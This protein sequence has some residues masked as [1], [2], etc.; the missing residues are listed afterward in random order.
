MLEQFH[1]DSDLIGGSLMVRES[2]LIADLLLREATTEQWHQAIQV[3]NILQKRTAASAQRNA[4]A[5]R[6]R[7]ERLEPDFWKA[8]RDGDDELATQ[9]A[10]CGALERNLLL[11]EFMETVMREAYI[12]Q[13]QYLDS[14]I[15]SDFLEERTQRDLDICEWKESSKKKMGQVVFRMLTEAGYLKSTRKLELQRVIVRAELRSLLEEHYKQR[16][17]RSMEVSLWMR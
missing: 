10:F 9:V 17:K 6:K 15:W 13:A 1:Y 11:L 7:L 2:R 5:I 4:T 14:Y 12:S 3:D 8:V 16:I